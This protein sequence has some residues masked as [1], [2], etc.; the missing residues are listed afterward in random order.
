MKIK[1]K[2]SQYRRDFTAIL[3]CEGC[4]HEKTLMSGYD[5]R[6]YHDNVL[7]NM[8]CPVCGNSRNDLGIIGEYT[9]TRYPEGMQI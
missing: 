2:L 3:I 5:D 6:Y 1:Q 4:G 8:K 7:P 9:E